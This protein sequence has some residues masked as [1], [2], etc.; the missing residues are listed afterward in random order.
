[1]IAEIIELAHP[2]LS[3]KFVTEKELEIIEFIAE[4]KDKI[5]DYIRNNPTDKD[6][7]LAKNSFVASF[8]NSGKRKEGKILYFFLQDNIVAVVA[9]KIIPNIFKKINPIRS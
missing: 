5:F 2:S 9:P 6:S 7:L 4:E 8:N 3:S 1:M